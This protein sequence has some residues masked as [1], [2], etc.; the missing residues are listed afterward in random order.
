MLI[1]HLGLNRDGE[2]VRIQKTERGVQ[3]NER[4]RVRERVSALHWDDLDL[5]RGVSTANSLRQAALQ[6]GL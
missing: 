3:K 5:L 1:C 2:S 4:C 6:L